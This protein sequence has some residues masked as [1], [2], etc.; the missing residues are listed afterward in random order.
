MCLRAVQV[1]VLISSPPA[2]L[3]RVAARLGAAAP[4]LAVLPNCGHLSHEEAPAVLLDF[5]AA[6]VSDAQQSAVMGGQ[7]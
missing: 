1:Q 7:G 6:F 2:S 4:R 5:L 3:T